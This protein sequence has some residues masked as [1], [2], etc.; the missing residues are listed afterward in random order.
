MPAWLGGF[1]PLKSFLTTALPPLEMT[2]R[3]AHFAESAGGALITI[4]VVV[5]GIA[6]SYLL[7]VPWREGTHAFSESPA[8]RPLTAFWMG[9]WGFDWATT[10]SSCGPS[11]GSRTRATRTWST[12][13]W[14]PSPGSTSSPGAG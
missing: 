1:D 10:G 4:A 14:A 11:G 7:W 13:W 12:T 3:Y 5:A 8:M 6:L 2:G 9:G